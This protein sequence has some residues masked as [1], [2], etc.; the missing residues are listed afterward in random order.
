[1]EA[2]VEGDKGGTRHLTH[3]EEVTIGQRFWCGRMWISQPSVIYFPRG[4][5]SETAFPHNCCGGEK[6]QQTQL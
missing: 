1:M 3:G 5:E 6:P 2:G 4:L